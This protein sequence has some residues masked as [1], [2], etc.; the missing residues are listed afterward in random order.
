MYFHGGI[1]LIVAFGMAVAGS[2]DAYLAKDYGWS[3]FF[4]LMS[5]GAVCLY[6]YVVNS[7]LTW[8]NPARD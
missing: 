1:L 3:W 4:A 7:W 2:Y 8:I 5:G 6:F